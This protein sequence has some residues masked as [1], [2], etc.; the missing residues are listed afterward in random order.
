MRF[1]L[2]TFIIML[3]AC[4][5]EPELLFCEGTKP[6]G[7]TVN[8]GTSFSTG[9][10][11]AVYKNKK[12]PEAEKFDFT[13]YEMSGSK[14]QRISSMSSPVKEG[15]KIVTADLSLYNIGAYEIEVSLNGNVIAKGGLKIEEGAPQAAEVK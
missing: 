1:L 3:A 12:H 9:D 7:S 13:V 14:K 4:G 5:K 15:A 6:D 2:F 10:F 8:C 11:M